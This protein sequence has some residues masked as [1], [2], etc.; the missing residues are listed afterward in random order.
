M[1]TIINASLQADPTTKLETWLFQQVAT[2]QHGKPI[3]RRLAYNL[4]SF[5]GDP[6][7]YVEPAPSGGS[8]VRSLDGTGDPIVPGTEG[9]GRVVGFQ[10]CQA[11]PFECFAINDVDAANNLGQLP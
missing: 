9:T 5:D 11:R 6:T 10:F 7:Q 3:Y 4:V 1:P 8:F 2:T